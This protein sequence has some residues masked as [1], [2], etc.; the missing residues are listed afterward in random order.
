[1][2]YEPQKFPHSFLWQNRL[3]ISD[4]VHSPVSDTTL[5]KCRRKNSQ[6]RCISDP[7]EGRSAWRKI[8][9]RQRYSVNS[10]C[11]ATRSI[12]RTPGYSSGRSGATLRALLTEPPQKVRDDRALED[13]GEIPDPE[14]RPMLIGCVSYIRISLCFRWKTSMQHLMHHVTVSLQ[15][16]TITLQNNCI[17]NTSMT[18]PT[19]SFY[20]WLKM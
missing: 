14:G 19:L 5:R 8:I 20:L 10:V 16:C 17:N 6:P 12:P 2:I 15:Q 3:F 4:D 1:M 9:R 18:Q 13:T 11:W 7:P